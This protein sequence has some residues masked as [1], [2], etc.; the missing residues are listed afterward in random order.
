MHACVCMCACVRA[1]VYASGWGV[2]VRACVRACVCA[3]V[4]ACVCVCVCVCACLD[5]Y[6][7]HLERHRGTVIE[8]FNTLKSIYYYRNFAFAL[9]KHHS[10]PTSIPFLP[11]RVGVW[12]HEALHWEKEQERQAKVSVVNSL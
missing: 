10:V 6:I 9:F 11:A 1:C 4:R 2:S 8:G 5:H 7:L 12:N 3:C